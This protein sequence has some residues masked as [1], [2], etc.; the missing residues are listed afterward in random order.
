MPYLVIMS[1]GEIHRLV[2]IMAKLAAVGL[3]H[4]VITL[5]KEINDSTTL[6]LLFIDTAPL[7]TKYRKIR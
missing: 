4:L 6:R 3:C 5:C 2:W 7:I 1:I